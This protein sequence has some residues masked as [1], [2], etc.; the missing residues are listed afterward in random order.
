MQIG[1]FDFSFD[2]A[3][4]ASIIKMG[5]K[6]SGSGGGSVYAYLGKVWIP[7]LLKVTKINENASKNI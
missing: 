4:C 2:S 6:L 7:L 3:L 5:A 1:K